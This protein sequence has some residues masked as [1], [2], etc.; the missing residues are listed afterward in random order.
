VRIGHLLVGLLLT[1]TAIVIAEAPTA[2]TASTMPQATSAPSEIDGVWVGIG[3]AVG[4]TET[5]AD[6]YHGESMTI[7][8]GRLSLNQAPF[9]SSQIIVRPK[10]AST[11]QPS[12]FDLITEKGIRN[13]GIYKLEGDKLT[14]FSMMS[15]GQAYGA[16]TLARPTSFEE[17]YREGPLMIVGG[18]S[19]WKRVPASATAPATRPAS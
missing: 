6:R 15:I 10:T 11:T 16:E 7:E 13:L 18:R 5:P 2:P 19:D 17:F 14:M 3:G 8:R 12:E 1:T 9:S 4:S